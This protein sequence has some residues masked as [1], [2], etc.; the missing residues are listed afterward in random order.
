MENQV[1]RGDEAYSDREPDYQEHHNPNIIDLP[2]PQED[3]A[4]P[5][6]KVSANINADITSEHVKELCD[7]VRNNKE[8]V[9]MLEAF[10]RHLSVE[11]LSSEDCEKIR[12][13]MDKVVIQTF[14][15]KR[16]QNIWK[17][18][19]ASTVGLSLCLIGCGYFVKCFRK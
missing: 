8:S 3:A 15:L 19:L 14:E 6:P 5:I 17:I 10:N 13:H 4:K 2:V 11:N 9:N 18:I 1:I 12:E 16:S 7:G